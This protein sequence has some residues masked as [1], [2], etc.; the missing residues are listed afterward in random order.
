MFHSVE[1]LRGCRWNS[2]FPA[3]LMLLLEKFSWVPWLCS[4]FSCFYY[5]LHSPSNPS[6]LALLVRSFGEQSHL[7]AWTISCSTMKVLITYFLFYYRLSSPSTTRT[8]SLDIRVR[9]FAELS[10]LFAWTFSCSTMT[11]FITYFLFYFRLNAPSIPSSL[12]F[13][14]RSFGELSHHNA[15]TYSCGNVTLFITYFLF[16]Y[17][18]HSPSTPSSLDLLVRSHLSSSSISWLLSDSGNWF[19]K[20]AP[21]FLTFHKL[22]SSLRALNVFWGISYTL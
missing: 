4:Y 7:I 16:R 18:L 20:K 1:I 14:V 15:W 21:T 9:S 17:R 12:A 19:W 11:V 2:R 5:R 3:A 13:L 22:H 10:H 8:S 6:S